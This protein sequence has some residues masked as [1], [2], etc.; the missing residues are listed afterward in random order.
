MLIK[1]KN[2][3]DNDMNNDKKELKK[4]KNI[5]NITYKYPIDPVPKETNLNINNISKEI[6]NKNGNYDIYQL[7]KH[8]KDNIDD[9]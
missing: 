4:D 8:N 6:T 7:E 9:I 5:F 2:N 3:H 1:E